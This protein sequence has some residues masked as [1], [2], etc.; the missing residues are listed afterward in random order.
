MTRKRLKAARLLAGG[1]RPGEVAAACRISGETLRRWRKDPE[2]RAVVDSE[3]AQQNELIGSQAYALMLET[4]DTVH[5]AIKAG[6]EAT[7]RVVFASAPA[8]IRALDPGG[9]GGSA[10]DHSAPPALLREVKAID[11]VARRRE[12]DLDLSDKQRNRPTYTVDELAT[13]TLYPG[14]AKHEPGRICC[15]KGCGERL[16]ESALLKRYRV[17]VGLPMAAVCLE[18]HA[19]ICEAKRNLGLIVDGDPPAAAEAPAAVHDGSRSYTVGQLATCNEGSPDM[20]TSQP[21]C[22]RDGCGAA[23]GG[24]GTM[25][26]RE[27]YDGRGNNL[28]LYVC[29]DCADTIRRRR[30]EAPQDEEGE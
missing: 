2:F 20:P 6:D 29:D 18:H 8:F 28:M 23:L 25:L 3:V 26:L 22:A 9:G 19:E 1:D 14:A 12:A 17:S 21:I 10:G 5:V 24:S 30:E 4:L 13:K 15:I 27:D 7:S 11:E 16:D